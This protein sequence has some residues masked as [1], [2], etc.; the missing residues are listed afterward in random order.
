MLEKICQLSILSTFIFRQVCILNLKLILYANFTTFFWT[1]NESFANKWKLC[2][3]KIVEKKNLSTQYSVNFYSVNF[4][5]V[6]SVF[7]QLL[8]CQLL[9]CQLCFCQLLFC[10]LCFCQLLWCQLLFCQLCF[11]Q[12]SF[13]NYVLSTLILSN[14]DDQHIW[15]TV[16]SVIFSILFINIGT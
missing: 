5:F 11:C 8:F 14:H 2:Y 7:C 4:Y 12:L 13:V 9:F 15:Q 16:I 3:G 1:K 6:N 10:Q